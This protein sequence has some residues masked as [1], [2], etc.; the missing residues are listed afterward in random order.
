[1]KASKQFAIDLTG[2]YTGRMVATHYQPDETMLLKTTKDFAELNLRLGYTFAV[3]NN[4]NIELFGGIQNMFN[5][6]Q[7]D[8]DKGPLRDSDYVYGPTKPR[9]FTFGIKIG[10]FH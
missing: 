2:V 9:T 5:A 1:I 10:H 3:R 6:F 7:K 8:F 4:F